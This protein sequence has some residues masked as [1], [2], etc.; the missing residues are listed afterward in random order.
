M[1]QFN[2]SG[3]SGQDDT[4]LAMNVSV[5]HVPNYYIDEQFSMSFKFWTEG[6]ILT[7]V[8]VFGIFANCLRY[9]FK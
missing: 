4:D 8:S 3:M 2:M 1:T 7:A 5:S 6:V 9:E